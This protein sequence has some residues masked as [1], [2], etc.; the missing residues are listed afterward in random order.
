VD[1]ELEAIDHLRRAQ[2][3]R[4]LW[5]LP[6]EQRIAIS[7]MDIGGFTAAEVAGMTGSPRGT[8]LA[9]VHR[10]RKALARLVQQQERRHA[11]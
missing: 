7:L 5:A 11:P 1:V 4:A 2:L 9:R 8:V 10:G 3:D 6:A